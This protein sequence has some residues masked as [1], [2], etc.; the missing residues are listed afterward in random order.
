MCAALL[1]SRHYRND[2]LRYNASDVVNDSSA[3]LYPVIPSIYTHTRMLIALSGDGRSAR[4]AETARENAASAIRFS[5]SGRKP[6]DSF[7]RSFAIYSSNGE[8]RERERDRE[9]FVALNFHLLRKAHATYR[10]SCKL[11]IIAISLKIRMS[12][13]LL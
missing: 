5:R 2:M 10:N 4:D 6:R 12:S 11:E 3:R 8:E 7:I 1:R 9:I 13:F